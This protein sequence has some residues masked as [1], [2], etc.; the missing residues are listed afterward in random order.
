MSGASP[1]TDMNPYASPSELKIEDGSLGAESPADLQP[2]L[3][4]WSACAPI[5]ITSAIFALLHLS[6]G[7][8]WIPLFF[9]AA[10]MGYLY[11]R[12]HRLLP[13]LTVHALL[14]GLSMWGLW[15]QVHAE[16]FRS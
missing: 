12:T 1:N 5:G 15:V 9:L 6:H 3:F 14:N 11:Q 16:G 13:S 8:D 2:E 4:G 7:P 10:G